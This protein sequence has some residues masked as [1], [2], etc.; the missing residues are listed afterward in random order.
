[1][2]PQFADGSR[3][4]VMLWSRRRAVEKRKVGWTR[5]QRNQ[6]VWNN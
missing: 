5:V 3:G 1:M 6:T 2:H 4:E